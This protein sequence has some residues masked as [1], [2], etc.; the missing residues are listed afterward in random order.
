LADEN[1]W[2]LAVLQEE[3]SALRG[4]VRT[5]A[6]DD[7]IQEDLSMDSLIAQEL[8][9][10]VEDRHDVELLG[11]ARLME[12]RTVGDLVEVIGERAPQPVDGAA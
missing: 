1:D 3:Y 5:L 11:D 9:A 7:R 8:L 12:V 4:G 10:A 2:V 6:L